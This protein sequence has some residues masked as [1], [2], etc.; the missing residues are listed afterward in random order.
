MSRQPDLRTLIWQQVAAI[1]RGRVSTY[2][3]IARLAGY[4]H[5]ARYVGT[6]L[7]QLPESSQL[8]W[9][10]V[11]NARG[12]IA[13]A[14]GSPAWQRQRQRLQEEGIRFEADQRIAL[15]RYRWPDD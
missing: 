8:P 5:H 9:H 3:Q 10:R 7:R 14:E 4:P 2:G 13:F 6:T 11:I 15:Y 1:P 12:A